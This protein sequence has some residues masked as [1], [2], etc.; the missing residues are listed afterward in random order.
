MTRE[1]KLL[2]IAAEGREV[3]DMDNVDANRRHSPRHGIMCYM[4]PA[5]NAVRDAEEATAEADMADYIANHKYKDDRRA[6]YPDL[7]DFADAVYWAQ[8]G[9]D[10]KM[11]DWIACCD[12]VKVNNPKL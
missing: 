4:L 3:V 7:G 8:K 6:E 9:D 11:V 2:A 10:S 5:E 12:A 1:E